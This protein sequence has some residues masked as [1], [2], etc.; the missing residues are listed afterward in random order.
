MYVPYMQACRPCKAFT[1]TYKRFAGKFDDTVFLSVIGEQ[2]AELR[3]M[4]IALNIRQTPTFICF[5]DRAIVHRHKGNN[6]ERMEEL[7]SS[8]WQSL[9]DSLTERDTGDAFLGLR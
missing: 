4:M 7:L 2:S 8:D 9:K 1:L 6:K 3:D 5:Y